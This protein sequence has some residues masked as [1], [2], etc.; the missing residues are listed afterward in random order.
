MTSRWRL[1]FADG[2]ERHPAGET[3]GDAPASGDLYRHPAGGYQDG[4]GSVRPART[5]NGVCWHAR[6]STPI[7]IWRPSGG[8]PGA[9]PAAP[10]PTRLDRTSGSGR[11]WKRAARQNIAGAD[12]H[13]DLASVRRFR[14]LCINERAFLS[15][16]TAGAAPKIVDAEKKLLGQRI[17]T[18]VDA[19]DRALGAA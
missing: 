11:Q 7:S 5:G 6:D 1:R 12:R 4:I 13:G 18:I 3:A 9:R 19:L 8:S 14:R 17:D 15:F 10:D 2:R 16:G